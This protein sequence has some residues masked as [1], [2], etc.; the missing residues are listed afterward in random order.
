MLIYR[1]ITCGTIEEKIYRKQV[2]KGSLMNIVGRKDEQQPLYRYFT[3]FELKLSREELTAMFRLDDPSFSATQ[4]QLE[5]IHSSHRKT[6]QV[7]DSHL[8]EMKAIEH[9]F[10]VSDHDLL[11]TGDV[12]KIE[13]TPVADKSTPARI[14]SV[15]KGRRR[16]GEKGEKSEKSARK[17]RKKR[18]AEDVPEPTHQPVRAFIDL[19][20]E[21]SEYELPIP[22][23]LS[24][25][26]DKENL[27]VQESGEGKKREEISEKSFYAHLQSAAER[28]AEGQVEKSLIHLIHALKYKEDEQVKIKILQMAN[29][30]PELLSACSHLLN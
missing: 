3:E 10:G 4:Q 13:N 9:F 5:E 12:G 27:H 23:R 28:E 20:K 30:H 17:P 26:E 6:D 11:F 8:Q 16:D 15:K 25:G 7:L 29:Q 1:L 21:E 2:Y 18:G 19:E 14:A 24:F 22:L